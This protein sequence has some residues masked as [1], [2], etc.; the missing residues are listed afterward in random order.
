MKKILLLLTVGAMLFASGC[1]DEPQQSKTEK[2]KLP[3]E[4]SY[5]NKTNSELIPNGETEEHGDIEEWS[6]EDELPSEDELGEYEEI[7]MDGDNLSETSR[8]GWV[9]AISLKDITV[10]TYNKITRYK[11]VGDG[12]N[13][14]DHVKPGDAVLLSF[15]ENDDGTL[16]AYEVGRVRVEDKPLSK[17]DI[18]GISDEADENEE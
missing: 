6:L 11:L 10:N 16:S 14:I 5:E 8:A 15:V 13:C 3:K 18:L 4:Y 12:K 2:A 9:L 17:D 1:K 7:L